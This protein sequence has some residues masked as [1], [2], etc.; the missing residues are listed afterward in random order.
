[1]KNVFEVSMN[2]NMQKAQ[3]EIDVITERILS[4]IMDYD[5]YCQSKEEEMRHR[6]EMPQRILNLF[7]RKI[8]QKMMTLKKN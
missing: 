2:I 4:L 5:D 6:N 8:A 1:M 7:Q 3:D